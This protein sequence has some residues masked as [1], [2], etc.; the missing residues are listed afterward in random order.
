MEHH[1]TTAGGLACQLGR[2][3]RQPRNSMVFVAKDDYEKQVEED[4]A[5]KKGDELEIEK[6]SAGY[7]WQATSR[8]TGMRGY[9]PS[10]FFAPKH[11]VNLEAQL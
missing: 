11:A 3:C 2:I 10:N 8:R 7:W 6:T 5:F 4:L 1:S 9:V